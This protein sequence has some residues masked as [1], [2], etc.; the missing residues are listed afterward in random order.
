MKEYERN[1]VEFITQEEKQWESTCYM[2]GG[3]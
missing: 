2:E 3:H 1:K